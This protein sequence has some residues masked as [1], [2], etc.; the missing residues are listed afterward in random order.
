V[1]RRL[2]RLQ[3]HRL[4]TRTAH[5]WT[6]CAESAAVGLLTLAAVHEQSDGAGERQR[7]RHEAERAQRQDAYQRWVAARKAEH[8]RQLL[9]HAVREQDELVPGDGWVPL[10]E[11]VG[12]LREHGDELAR[13]RTPAASWAEPDELTAPALVDELLRVG[14]L[15]RVAQQVGEPF[16]RVQ[17]ALAGPLAQL[18]AV[19]RT[20]QVFSDGVAR[21][22]A[23][24]EHELAAERAAQGV[25]V[26]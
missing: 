21:W 1:L 16:R 19:A 24:H 25:S 12:Q 14:Q 5:G 26:D 4:V 3:V 23:E 7:E 10:D 6:R 18:Q 2:E 15:L 9:E 22:A 20:V 13:E 17:D 8:R 11:L